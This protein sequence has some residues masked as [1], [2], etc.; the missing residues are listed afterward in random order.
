M[1]FSGRNPTQITSAHVGPP[2]SGSKAGGPKSS[3]ASGAATELGGGGGS[4]GGGKSQSKFS[5]PV[6]PRQP[7]VTGWSTDD[8]RIFAREAAKINLKWARRKRQ[9]G[10][11]ITNQQIDDKEQIDIS[12]I[13]EDKPNIGTD[14]K[15]KIM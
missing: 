10:Y 11:S 13:F 4:G 6:Q 12:N 14:T 15:K 7:T 2:T 5:H 9:T 8:D 3:G 1:H